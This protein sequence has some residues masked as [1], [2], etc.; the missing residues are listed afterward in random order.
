MGKK[1]WIHPQILKQSRSKFLK[2]HTKAKLYINYG[3]DDVHEERGLP[4]TSARSSLCAP[5]FVPHQQAAQQVNKSLVTTSQFLKIQ[6]L[7][8][9]KISSLRF[10]KH[11]KDSKNSEF[12]NQPIGTTKDNSTF[13]I[14]VVNTTT[15]TSQDEIAIE[16]KKQQTK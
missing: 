14:S 11:A 13:A 9:K 16:C 8:T 1:I 7:L 12:R 5:S 15:G 4:H 3:P 2:Q 6:A 10:L